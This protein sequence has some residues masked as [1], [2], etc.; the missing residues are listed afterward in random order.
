MTN[1]NLAPCRAMVSIEDGEP[2]ATHIQEHIDRLP[3]EALKQAVVGL[4]QNIDKMNKERDRVDTLEMEQKAAE[5][6]S[7]IKPL[8]DEIRLHADNLE[9]VVDDE[10]WPLP[11]TREL[12][13]TR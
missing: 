3:N 9:M 8:M 11:K 5:Y 7:I 4:K 2:L 12:L 1:Q 10:I 6:A 13:F